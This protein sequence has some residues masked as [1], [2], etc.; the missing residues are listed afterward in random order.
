MEISNKIFIIVSSSYLANQSE[1]D[2]NKY[3]FTYTVKIHNKSNQPIQLMSRHWVIVDSNNKHE[4]VIGEGVIGKQPIIAPE[5][6]FEYTSGA[7]LETEIGTMEGFY[8][9]KLQDN[10]LKRGK[11]PKF[12]LSIPRTLH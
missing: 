3:V 6:F 12:T 2:E 10:K 5:S 8:N 4:E 1:P 11:I 9:F 7:I